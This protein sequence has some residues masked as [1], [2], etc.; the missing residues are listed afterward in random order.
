MTNAWEPPSSLEERLVGALLPPRLYYW[1]RAHRER[2]SGEPELG[3]LPTLVDPGRNSVDVGANKGVYTYWLQ[4]CSRHV[5]AY[6]PNPKMFRILHAAA[7]GNVTVSPVALSDATGTSMLRVPKTMGGY[8]N[9]GASLN[10]R[11][12]GPDY[13]EVAVETRRLDDAGLADVGFIKIDVEGHEMAVIEGGRELIARD[14]PTLLVRDRGGPHRAAHRGLAGAYRRARIP[15]IRR[16]S[17]RAHV[18]RDVRRDGAQPRRQR[19]RRL[20]LQFRVPAQ[21]VGAA[22]SRTRRRGPTPATTRIG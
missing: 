17:R 13:G 12:V 7:G 1:V 16:A 8:S 19:T 11:K 21:K 18:R 6:E 3:L 5:Y 20:R 2:L 10:Y 14:R 22:L 4:R 9:Q 15:G